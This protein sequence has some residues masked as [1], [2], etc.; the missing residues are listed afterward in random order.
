MVTVARAAF[1]V[2]AIVVTIPVMNLAV[3]TVMISVT[4][5]FFR[6]AGRQIAI[7]PSR[8]LALAP[9]RRPLVAVVIAVLIVV[10]VMVLVAVIVMMSEALAIIIV[11]VMSFTVVFRQSHGGQESG[12]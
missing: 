6:L 12:T 5:L 2:V 1:V 3:V 8:F 10:T 7:P 4:A 9:T 11:A